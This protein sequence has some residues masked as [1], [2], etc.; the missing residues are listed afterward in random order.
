MDE[1]SHHTEDENPGAAHQPLVNPQDVNLRL[2]PFGTCPLTAKER[3]NVCRRLTDFRCSLL[4]GR[5]PLSRHIYPV[6]LGRIRREARV[7][8]LDNLAASRVNAV[9]PGGQLKVS[10][11]LSFWLP[12]VAQMLA[13]RF[14][15][16]EA[17]FSLAGGREIH[18]C[19]PV[20][21]RFGDPALHHMTDTVQRRR[22]AG[23]GL[24]VPIGA[25]TRAK[26]LA[27]AFHCFYSYG[28]VARS[29]STRLLNVEAN[30]AIHYCVP[31]AVGRPSSQ[32]QHYLTSVDVYRRRL[33]HRRQILPMGL[34][35][36]V[37]RPRVLIF[38]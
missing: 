16:H 3:V 15:R 6:L 36:A 19:L 27:P 5:F 2:K 14:P 12:D 23:T 26:A 17:Y 28:T 13:L 25:R 7:N 31:G 37:V 22:M 33:I 1:T 9:V 35:N 20:C 18:M 8:I 11:F 21:A 38:P 32:G 24:R 29:V 34:R 4:S 30:W 10:H